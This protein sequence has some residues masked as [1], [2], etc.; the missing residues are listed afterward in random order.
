MQNDYAEALIAHIASGTPFDKALSGLGSVLVRK[1]HLKLLPAI[2]RLVLRTLES[3]KGVLKATTRTAQ[4]KVSKTE[5]ARLEKALADLGVTQETPTEKIVDETLIGG[6][7]VTY[8]YH[9]QD[10]SYKR[11]LTN[12]YESITA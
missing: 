9:E 3:E 6:F 1:H 10:H 11:V 7:I 8:A 4:A 5:Q 12:L 2:L